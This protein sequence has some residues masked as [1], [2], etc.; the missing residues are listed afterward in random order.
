M[1]AGNEPYVHHVVI[2]TCKKDM[3]EWVG[4]KEPC[5]NPEETIFSPMYQCQEEVGYKIGERGF[6]LQYRT[7]R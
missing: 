5:F 3:S 4:K 6:V 7:T 1:Q 2:S